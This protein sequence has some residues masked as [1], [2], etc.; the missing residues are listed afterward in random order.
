MKSIFLSLS[1]LASLFLVSYEANA[2]ADTRL[3][4]KI[5]INFNDPN[6]M[7]RLKDGY[8]SRGFSLSFAAGVLNEQPDLLW[9]TRLDFGGYDDTASKQYVSEP[10]FMPWGA[11]SRVTFILGGRVTDVC[12]RD[13]TDYVVD[14]ENQDKN[15][16]MIWD[17]ASLPSEVTVNVTPE[18]EHK[19]NIFG[20]PLFRYT[21]SQAN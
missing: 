7:C 10:F 8:N 2:S 11:D 18:D 1:A 12:G 5:T 17:D 6:G 15:C 20:T 4:P 21:C 14:R 13:G 16:T 9:Q 19:K 3:S